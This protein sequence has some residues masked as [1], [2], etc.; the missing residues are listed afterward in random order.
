MTDKQ[1]QQDNE[2]ADLSRTE[3]DT[4]D[5]IITDKY[6]IEFVGANIAKLVNDRTKR[7]PA[8]YGYKY[9]RDWYDR[10]Y[11]EGTLNSKYFISNAESV[12]T[13][14]SSLSSQIRNVV[15]Y[16]CNVS[17]RQMLLKTSNKLKID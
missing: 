1:T 5:K 6:F 15:Q 2:L 12:W 14:N 16:I 10:M 7:E 8:R 17:L 9:K 3:F 13:R 11:S 4:F